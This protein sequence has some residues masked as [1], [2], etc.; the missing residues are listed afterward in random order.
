MTE[1]KLFDEA[2]ISIDNGTLVINASYLTYPDSHYNV[3]VSG[4]NE[5]GEYTITGEKPKRT[6]NL[7]SLGGFKGDLN[8]LTDDSV[9][10]YKTLFGKKKLMVK[11][12]WIEFKERKKKTYTTNKIIIIE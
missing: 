1:N 10:E 8:L 12:G 3:E 9:E 5:H 2:D 6:I 7:N 11:D 4:P